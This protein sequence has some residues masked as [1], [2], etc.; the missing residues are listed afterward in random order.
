MEQCS[1]GR[2]GGTFREGLCTWLFFVV[3]IVLFFHISHIL[4]HNSGLRYSQC[5][6]AGSVTSIRRGHREPE[7]TLLRL[8]A[9]R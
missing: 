4:W 6:Q 1:M 2:K 5:Q 9:T 3:V 8:L 7:N